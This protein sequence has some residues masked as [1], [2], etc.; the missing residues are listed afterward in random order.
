[1]SAKLISIYQ[2]F[3]ALL[4]AIAGPFLLF[5][6][7]ARAG[8]NQKFGF[9]PE[10]IKSRSAQLEG[11]IWIHAVS[12]GEFNAALPLIRKLKQEQ[13][14]KPLVVSTATRTGQA[15]A[16]EKAS[17][18]AEIIYFPFDLPFCYKPWLDALKPECV[19]IIETELWPGFVMECHRRNIAVLS[20]NARMSPN[21]FTWYKRFKYFFEP[22]LKVFTRV[23]VQNASEFERFTALGSTPGKT[24]ILGNIKLDGM[25]SMPDSEKSKLEKEL[26][27]SVTDFVIVA[28][29]T[30]EGEEDALLNILAD[31]KKVENT[32]KPIKMIIVP[33][34]PERFE[35]ANEI[36]EQH[37]FT[38]KRFSKQE[39]FEGDNDIYL[40]DALGQLTRFYSIAS[41]AF[42]G[43]TIAKI[44]GHSLAEPYANSV[45][46]FC[47]PHIQ[48]TKDIARQLT[49]CDA[50]IMADNLDELKER[51]R[52][53]YI[54]REKG[55]KIGLNGSSW[56]KDNQGAVDRA[57]KMID[58]V[59]KKESVMTG[60]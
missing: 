16:K 1:M 35:R 4:L 39:F 43:G 15:Q 36:I 21:S 10:A 34:H 29:S 8:L 14:D 60:P 49:E 53:V 28:G 52:E 13:P 46:V 44:G 22:V 30:H 50:L 54:N 18:F 17:E 47:G 20:V 12:V 56:L 2:I 51:V 31:L 57:F 24:E 27:I 41:L 3:L 5:K 37:G 33:R 58:S 6:K 48:K 7:K 11:A 40:L 55:E 23:G 59:L 45:P 9:I 26:N 38:P 19:V 42:V 25:V 32:D